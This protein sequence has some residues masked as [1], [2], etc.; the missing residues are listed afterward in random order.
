MESVWEEDVMEEE[1]KRLPGK[2][3]NDIERWGSVIA[4]TAIAAYGLKMRSISGLVLSA[5]GG[6]LLWR[7]ASGHC[8]VYE[9][10]GLSSAESNGDNVSVP[11]GR[12]VRVEETVTINVPREEVYAFWRDFENLP[13]FMHN[14]ERVE[15][16]DRT[17]SHWW[18]KGPAGSTMDWE[19]EVINEVPGELIGWRSVDGSRV[20]NAG[21]VHF[22]DASDGIGTEIKVILRYDPPAGALGAA[23]SKILGEDPAQNVQEDLRRLKVLLE[24]GIPSGT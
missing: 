16:Q 15:V 21:S 10:L 9:A 3:I 23:I 14:L 2:N 11:Y 13:Q 1:T 24:A 4:G 17:R 5:V 19:A 22:A 18:T 7:G 20:D 12:G 6:A 8:M